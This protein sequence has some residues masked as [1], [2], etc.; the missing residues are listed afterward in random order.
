MSDV[1]R[2]PLAVGRV[3]MFTPWPP[4]RTGVAHYSSMIVP[5]LRKH[6]EV[7][8]MDGQRPTA[9]GQRRLTLIRP[10]LGDYRSSDAMPPLAMGILA[11]RAPGWDIAF[12][13]EKAEPVP[14]DEKTVLG[15]ARSIG[16]IVT[17][18]ENVPMGGFGS[19]VS[20]LFDREGL[21]STAL[22]R[23]AL[24][25]SF[26]THGKRDELLRRVGLDPA[27]IARRVR[28]WVRAQQPQDSHQSQYS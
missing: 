4:A 12:Y 19:A 3:E 27:G 23:I 2:W 7:A 9:N 18:E 25:E 24:P 20:E 22:L 28:E 6:I 14:L 8:V 17:V 21:S 11:A 1:G 10:N 16:R 26:V 13:D 15:L 5:A